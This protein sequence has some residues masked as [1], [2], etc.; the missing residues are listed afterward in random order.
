[1]TDNNKLLLCGVDVSAFDIEAINGDIGNIEEVINQ[2]YYQFIRFIVKSNKELT[3]NQELN[4]LC[5]NYLTFLFLK[6]FKTP[7]IVDKK[8]D[9]LKYI[10]GVLFYKH[11]LNMDTPL[12][13]ER[14]LTLIDKKL[15]DEFRTSIPDTFLNKYSDIKDV[16]KLS[17]DLKIVFDNPNTL[18]YQILSALKV[19]SFLSITSTFDHLLAAIVASITSTDYYKPLL[20]NRQMQETIEKTLI[21]YFNNVKYE[22]ITNFTVSSI[23]KGN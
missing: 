6:V 15:H 1:M 12:A 8:I 9:I 18:T 5:I 4:N 3:K 2:Y 21:P 7:T 10:V 22:E 11:Y 14:A 17:Y 13:K 16:I 19:V 23:T 20:L